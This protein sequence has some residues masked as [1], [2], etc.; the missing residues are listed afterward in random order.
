MTG[1][2]KFFNASKG[3]GFITNDETGQ[4]IFVHV[5]SLN[6]ETLNEGDKVEYV[7]E[8]GKKGTVA[9]QVQIL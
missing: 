9:G 3:Y 8:E 2:V 7:E 1:T 5:T 6:G 4:D